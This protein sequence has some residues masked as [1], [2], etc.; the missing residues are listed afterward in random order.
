MHVA[1]HVQ[2]REVKTGLTNDEGPLRAGTVLSCLLRKRRG[3]FWKVMQLSQRL[4]AALLNCN[5]R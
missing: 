2:T 5:A 4:A 3:A 1:L